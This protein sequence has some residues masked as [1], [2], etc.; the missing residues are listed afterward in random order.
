MNIPYHRAMRPLLRNF[1]KLLLWLPVFLLASP[2][3]FGQ[4]AEF[5]PG[6]IIVLLNKGT[7]INSFL[8]DF[9]AINKDGQLKA[10]LISKN[11]PIYLISHPQ[12]I[13]NEE[14]M[15]GNLLRLRSVSKAQLNYLVKPRVTTPDDTNYALQW[16]LNNTGQTGGTTDADVDAPEAWDI[17]TGGLT[18]AGDTIVVAIVDAGVQLTHP[19]LAPNIWRNYGEIPGNSIDDDGN[20]YVDDI[21]GWNA[22]NNTG[23]LATDNH[24]THVAG[25]I[26]ARGNNTAG[27]SGINWNVKL[28]NI[29][30][31]S[32][33]TA[34]VVSAYDYALTQRELYN[35]TN[36]A[37]G[38]FV[39]AVNSSFG[40][41]YGQASNFTVWCDFYNTMGAAGILNVGATANQNINVEVSGDIPTTCTSD[42][43]VTVTNSTHLD[44]KNGGS[45]YGTTSI[46][47]AAPGTSINSTITGSNYGN[48]SGTS[49]AT[50][51]VAGIIALM[52]SYPCP[53]IGTMMHDDPDGFALLVK[54]ALLKGV[55][56]LAAFSTFTVTSGRANA[57]KALDSLSTLCNFPEYDIAGRVYND[58]NGLNGSPSNTVS[59]TGANA[60]GLNAVL[61]NTTSNLVTSHVAVQS[62]GNFEFTDIEGG[63]YKIIITSSA[64][65]GTTVPAVTLPAGWV[66]TGEYLGAGSGSDGFP[67]GSLNIGL[68]NADLSNAKFGI[69]RPPVATNSSM[70]PQVNPG[71]NASVGVTG[72]NCTDPSP[73][74]VTRIHFTTYPSNAA[75]VF[76]ALNSY[77]Q[78]SWPLG[79]VTVTAMGNQP[80]FP[81]SIDPVSGAQTVMINYEAV[82]AA[83][84]SSNVAT[85]SVPFT[86]ITLG[87]KVSNDIDG[88]L[89]SP[90]NT[91][92]GNG[93]SFSGIKAV[94]IDAITDTVIAISNV[95]SANGNY[96]FTNRDAGYYKVLIT[97]AGASVGAAPP[98]VILPASWAH[99][100]EYNG[101]GAGS[102]GF[103]DGRIYLDWQAVNNQQVKF[104]IQQPPTANNSFVTTQINPG[105]S[106][107]ITLAPSVF[108]TS[109]AAPGQVT[110]VYFETLP[111]NTEQLVLNGITYS[112]TNPLPP[113]GVHVVTN[114]S[115]EPIQPILLNPVEGNI[116]VSLSYKAVDAS[117]MKSAATTVSIP[118][119]ALTVSGK[120]HNDMNG[121]LGSPS[122]TI[123]GAG[124]NAGTLK[125]V[126]INNTTNK[127]AAKKNVSANGSFSFTDVPGGNYAVLITTFNS[128][129]QVPPILLP[130]GWEHTGEYHTTGTGND[131]AVNGLLELGA[132]SADISTIRFGIR[133]P[134]MSSSAGSPGIA[135]LVHPEENGTATRVT[136][137]VSIYPNP[138]TDRVFVK[139]ND[140]S[141]LKELR[142][143][144]IKGREIMFVKDGFER[145]IDLSGQ[146]PGTY[147]LK[148]IFQ[149]R[150]TREFKVLKK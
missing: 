116:S 80:L 83:G 51:M 50:P 124:T 78:S 47:L 81:I 79:G 106:N 12:F 144:D 25:I 37:Q 32:G 31:S 58:V 5:V 75:S 34:T 41:D 77:T 67:D 150:S 147:I 33:S 86:A 132:L 42:Y 142:L 107:T 134:A 112:P 91:V 19:D 117:G 7:A 108:V 65:S 111:A 133:Q 100:S 149:N 105:G 115:G 8:Q 104:G 96:S 143:T 17:T 114:V 119:Y 125:A 53:T 109:D 54:D 2:F 146:L 60:G 148:L 123:D 82:D 66:N 88:L 113:S 15:T 101:A 121:L 44:Q 30:G 49:M 137:D 70:A 93:I 130:A 135:G 43:L 24:G 74:S 141:V 127:V 102:D 98:V 23:T 18:A 138:A 139:I 84:F 110:S 57:F 61:V 38:A 97:K 56:N 99:T 140:L 120:V 64:V 122:N 13:S 28:M 1:R 95:S 22:Y 90:A 62:N 36:G 55:D 29:C 11:L 145:G 76:I 59:G 87:G 69:E 16:A 128:S 131:G 21:N 92:N 136:P 94:L 4:K 52:Y 71:S 3:S 85:L 39:V 35:S 126:L 89:G 26:G 45:A 118:F 103:A 63:N 14:K 72:Y 129:A 68:L 40:V 20:G 10:T 48:L 9:T 6:E 27:V 73:G 46:D